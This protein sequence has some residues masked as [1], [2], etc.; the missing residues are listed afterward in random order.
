MRRTVGRWMAFC[1][2]MALVADMSVA[3]TFTWDNDGAAPLNDGGG[4]WTAIGGQNWF[5]GV[6]AY[7]AWGNTSS[8]VAVFGVAN[9]SAATVAVGTVNANGLTFNPPGS[10]T[11][12]LSGGTIT[13][14]GTT[15]TI[16]ANTNATVGSALT[17]S[18]SLTKAGAGMLTLSGKSM[19][20]GNTT[21]SGGTLKITGGIYTNAHSS[22]TVT[23]Q[24]GGVLEIDTWFYGSS[25]SLGMLS[26][27]TAR[28]VVNNGRIRVTGNTS[29]GRGVTLNGPAILE[30]AAGANWTI[31]T[32]STG[33]NLRDWNYNNNAMVLTGAGTGAFQK[34]FLGSG[35]LTKSGAGTWIL[36]GTNTYSGGT[37]ISG[38]VLQLGNGGATG[39]LAPGGMISN[40][41]TLTFKRSDAITQGVHFAGN[42]ISGSGNVVQAG[43]G[44]TVLTSTN[45]YSGGTAINAGVLHFVPIHAMPAT[46]TVTVN[47]SCLTVSVGAADEWG[48]G[49]SGPGSIGGLLSGVGGQSGSLIAYSG[50]VTLGFDTEHAASAQVY[51]GALTNVGTSLSITK[52]GAGTL[53]LSAKNLYKGNTTVN[54]GTLKIT[55]GIYTNGHSSSVVTVQNG[56]VLELNTWAYNAAAESLG[57]LAADA[58]Q[59]VVNNGTIR[60]NGI[61]SYGRGVTLNGPVIL[62]AASGANWTIN[63]TSYDKK[64]WVYNNKSVELAGAGIGTFEKPFIGNGGLTKSGTGTWTLSG[65]NTFTGGTAI[66]AG[67]L[68]LAATGSISNSPAIRVSSGAVFDVSSV[69]GYTVWSRQCLAGSGMV[70]GNVTLANGGVLAAGG[71][72]A[73]GALSFSTNLTLAASAV[74]DWNYSDATQDVIVV[75]GTLTLPT[76][77]TVNVSRV[78]GRLPIKGVL[79]TFGS[80]SP[81]SPDLSQWVITGALENTRATVLGNPNRVVLVSPTGTLLRVL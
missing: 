11:Y 50:A 47:G 23:V 13:L 56:G 64:S 43:S 76:V 1:A 27:D 2:E 21:V 37:V 62:E 42:A 19:Y 61:T 33:T 25:Q 24:N 18:A 36:S 40:N 57:M 80:V 5:D 39:T 12:T 78:T 35:G 60:M 67:T 55:G 54:G 59:I 66:N 8:D 49:T 63:D 29:Y 26:A 17:G 48:V 41:A 38:G 34:A 22:S 73:T 16:T 15:P 69:S 3:G 45:T 53:T 30:A 44:K 10:G 28:I 77:A 32:T 72:N 9:G 14:G 74:I 81:S 79:F 65:T 7:G 70:T 75:A 51:A 58:P 46:G 20:S 71:T 6:S 4:N 68:K 52:S 31:D